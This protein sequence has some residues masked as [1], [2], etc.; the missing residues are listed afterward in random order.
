MHW[1]LEKQE[2][3]QALMGKIVLEAFFC[4]FLPFSVE[5]CCTTA[6]LYHSVFSVIVDHLYLLL[7]Y[8]IF[9]LPSRPSKVIIVVSLDA[10]KFLSRNFQ[11]NM[12]C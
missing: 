6:Y 3:L 10:V 12:D 2:T 1:K 7:S 4:S 9:H 5:N 8:C 11:V